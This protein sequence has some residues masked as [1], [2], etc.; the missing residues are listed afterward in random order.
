ML[1]PAAVP[2]AEP[3]APLRQA[4]RR[5]RVGANRG[6]LRPPLGKNDP[7]VRGLREPARQDSRSMIMAMPCPPPTHMVSRPNCLSCHDSEFTSVVVIRD[8]LIPKG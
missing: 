3:T 1:G 2:G 5:R 6:R 8:P 7:I 4:R